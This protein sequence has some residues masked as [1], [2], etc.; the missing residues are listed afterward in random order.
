M[1]HQYGIVID[2]GSSG[3]RVHVYRWPAPAAQNTAATAAQQAA[4]RHAPPAVSQDPGWTMKISP[5]VASFASRPRAVWKLHYR[6]LVRFAEAIVPA[7]QLATTP[8]YILS[9]GG[10]RLLPARQRQAILA[11]T[12]RAVQR[13]SR[14]LVASC[15]EHVQ[16]IDGAAEG[17]YGWVALNQL[18]G[19]FA[20]GAGAPETARSVGFLDMGGASAQVAFEPGAAA[21]R[22]HADALAT[23][24][25]RLVDGHAQQWRVF[26]QTWLGFGAN[27]GR[28][29]H[30]QQLVS[31]AAAA[32]GGAPPAVVPDPCMPK[33]SVFQLQP[34][35][36]PEHT[37]EGTGDYAQCA[38]AVYPLLMKHVPCAAQPCLFNGVHGPRMDFAA[39]RFVGVAEY[40][41]TA[42]D[43]L[44][45]GGEYTA[46]GFVAKTRAFCESPWA[47]VLDNQRRGVY[48]DVSA[49]QLQAACFKAAWV[50]SVLHEGL[51]LPRL[52]G[53]RGIDGAGIDG[54]GIDGAG[55]DGAGIDGAGIN[56]AGIDEAGFEGD[57][58]DGAGS[59]GAGSEGEDSL[60]DGSAP[61]DENG[62]RDENGSEGEDGLRDDAAPGLPRHVPFMSANAI[63]GIEISWTLGK[64][65]LVAAAQIEPADDAV[66]GVVPST[67]ALRALSD[68]DDDS[69]DDPAAVSVP[70]LVH[71]ALA[72]A[73]VYFVYRVLRKALASQ[74]RRLGGA[75][76]AVPRALRGALAHARG[77]LPRFCGPPL[78]RALD[79]FERRRHDGA[80]SDLEEGRGGR[81]VSPRATVLRTRSTASFGDA[82]PGGLR[83]GEFMSKPFANPKSAG[84]VGAPHGPRDVPLK[85]LSS[86]SVGRLGL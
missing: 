63:D 57:G 18:L 8:V 81:A 83:G 44:H 43:V 36:A 54:A 13:H 50:A 51:G 14:L 22:R 20:R 15:A 23:V 35:G 27:E 77:S 62:L 85:L 12:C 17:V 3:S 49:A 4:V 67:M 47:T 21:R 61:R 19:V 9:T 30:L 58:I 39:A 11:E 38:R 60:R 37:V 86:G 24:T 26:V 7:A 84:F 68:S 69:D 74:R 41:Y 76:A 10:M 59:D 71:V 29:R 33:G 80:C 42:H 66:V 34:D 46:A 56:G 28:R 70:G 75:D 1:S 40:W 52:G 65:L 45:S 31:L 55:I 79:F 25:L 78:G 72:A 82:L 64:M 5:G 53:L 16:T 48:G 32:A 2:S 73:V 6:Q